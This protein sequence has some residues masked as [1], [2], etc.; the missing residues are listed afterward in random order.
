MSA[1]PGPDDTDATAR[2]DRP[3]IGIEV[4]RRAESRSTPEPRESYA[5]TPGSPD[6]A[7]RRGR[8]LALAVLVA[9]GAWIAVF[10]Y[11]YAPLVPLGDG[12]TWI[13]HAKAYS[14]RGLSGFWEEQPMVHAQ[15]LYLLPSSIALV[16]G[17]L[18][19]Y[20]FRPFAFLSSALVLGCGLALYR[21]GRA[22]GLGRYEALA[23]FA[24]VTT[25]RHV[26]NLLFG[27]QIGLPLSVLFGIGAIVC[28]G[29]SRGRGATLLALGLAAG[30]L[31]CSSAGVLSCAVVIAVR[32]LDLRRPRTLLASALAILAL[33]VLSHVALTRMVERSFFADEVALVSFSS[34]PRI[35]RDFVKLLGGGLVGGAAATPFGLVV[36]AAG[37]ARV[38][39]SVRASRRV[40]VLSGLALFGLAATLAIAIARAPIQTPDSRH[41]I[42]AVPAVAVCVLDL[43]RW[44]SARAPQH[45]SARVAL[46]ASLAVGLAWLHADA[47]LDAMALYRQSVAW[48][49]DTRLF[50]GAIAGDGKLS[51]EE[52]RQVNPG[53]TE[54]IRSLMEYARDRKLAIS[55]P[56]YHGLVVHDGLPTRFAQ[57]ARGELQAGILHLSGSGY[58]YERSRCTFPSGG[59]ARLS[60]DV[61]VQ[62][63]ATFGFIVRGADGVEKA[64]VA[65]TLEP[66]ADF[67]VRSIRARAAEGDE[68]DA[69]VFSASEADSVRLR[70]FSTV[71]VQ[72]S[73]IP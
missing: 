15:H 10:A 4:A 27:F 51:A 22:A 47:H 36:L 66:G 41:A 28:A 52:I 19:D 67:A 63:Q 2:E 48:D 65:A 40:D 43:V 21:V 16:L 49:L 14:E 45:S 30:S 69:Y 72:S 57:A 11:R 31:L 5:R 53:E 29:S 23:V 3:Q 62:G 8:W 70:S 9:I 33:V 71:L 34:A 50:L 6:R 58:V 54:R 60:V 55:S 17:P 44:L 26:E 42:F 37:I 13:A 18:V 25:L 20:S 12:W 59:V 64:N 35:A 38:V 73:P 24:A 1:E 46:A 61:A 32:W 7:S 39:V 68:L 56:S